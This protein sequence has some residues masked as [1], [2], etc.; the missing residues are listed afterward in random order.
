MIKKLIKLIAA[1]AILSYAGFF[2]EKYRLTLPPVSDFIDCAGE[3]SSSLSK[4]GKKI[5]F[6]EK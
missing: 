4:L 6:G 5:N 1:A 3:I 2:G